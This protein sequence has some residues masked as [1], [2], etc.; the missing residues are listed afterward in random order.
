MWNN[1]IRVHMIDVPGFDHTERSDGE[2]FRYIAG[3]MTMAYEKNTNLSG[4]I[5]LH[6]ITD[7]RMTGSSMRNLSMFKELCGSKCFSEVTLVLTCLDRVDPAIGVAREHELTTS[8]QFWGSMVKQGSRV[9]RYSHSRD[10]A[11]SIVDSVVERQ[12]MVVLDV[13][14]EMVNRRLRLDETAAGKFMSRDFLN[15]R[16]KFQQKI[17]EL[18]DE[19]RVATNEKDQKWAREIDQEHEDLHKQIDQGDQQMRDLRMS[20]ENLKWER[21]QE[22]EKIGDEISQRAAEYKTKK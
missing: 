10:S 21:E 18:Q 20:F 3:W 6:R 5:Y 8:E 7:H 15:Q 16:N 1:H 11:M 17:R 4:I 13:Q 9:A 22:Y 12:R 14:D 19:M 2:I